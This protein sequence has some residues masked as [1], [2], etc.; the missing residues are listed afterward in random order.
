MPKSSLEELERVC[1]RQD[2]EL[3]ALKEEFN[4]YKIWVEQRL[5]LRNDLTQQNATAIQ[6]L[7]IR[8]DMAGLPK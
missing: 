6:T 1:I 4:Q 3:R 2:K 5:D 8:M 7:S